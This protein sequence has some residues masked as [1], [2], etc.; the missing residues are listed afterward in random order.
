MP[1][2]RSLVCALALA[3]L[4]LAASAAGAAEPAC[5]RWDLEV[6][7]QTNPN[8]VIVTDPFTATVTVK[9]TG[10]VALT[11][12]RLNLRPD[13]GARFTDPKVTD[14]KVLETVIDKLEPGQ[15]QQLSATLACDTVGITRVLGG[16]RD[17]LG[18]AAASCACTVDVYGLPALHAE[19]KDRDLQGKSKGQ[20]VV[21]DTFQY[22]FEV[23]DDGGT[24]VTPD[25]K[26]VFTLPKELEFVSGSAER[27]IAVSG[28]GQAAESTAFALGPSEGIKMSIQVKVLAAPPSHLV[29]TK[30]V[31]LTATGLSVAE[32]SESTTLKE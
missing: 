26:I 24:A 1:N 8:R 19:M 10:D 6:T 17:S 25:L 4:P 11:S 30:A 12:V 27:S 2:V 20:F 13:L 28:A 21:G 18:W 9:N 16:A 23:R 32:I 3:S 22:T 5:Q 14:P 31:V 15:T 7:C 29:A